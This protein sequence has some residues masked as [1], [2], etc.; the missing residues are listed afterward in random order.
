MGVTVA[1]LEQPL[2]DS[3]IRV[4]RLGPCDAV[5]FVD[6]TADPQV[7]QFAHLP[8][9]EYTEQIFLE[10]LRGVIADGLRDG[11][12]AVLAVANAAT[13]EFWGS[14]TLFDVDYTGGRAEIGFWVTPASRG[15]GAAVRAVKLVAWWAARL[16]IGEL[17]ARADAANRPSCA[18]L[19][20]ADFTLVDGP[21]EQTAPS[22]R[23]F[24]GLTYSRP[25][26]P[27]Q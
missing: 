4:R 27:A 7:R 19:E 16:G 17:M 26:G 13:D 1:L 2:T 3:V 14:I 25:S 23:T 5:A 8:L 11:N 9:D 15:R 24:T 20:R 18:V 12:L 10:Q 21:A 6:G 22:G